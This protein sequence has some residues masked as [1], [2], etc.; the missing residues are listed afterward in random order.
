MIRR[1]MD[2]GRFWCVFVIAYQGER[3]GVKAREEEK[4]EAV[5]YMYKQ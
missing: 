1:G 3:R 5:A 4:R 2:P